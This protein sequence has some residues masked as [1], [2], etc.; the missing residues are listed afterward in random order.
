MSKKVTLLGVI[1]LCLFNV[2]VF[3]QSRTVTLDEENTSIRAILKKIEKQTKYL[4]VYDNAQ[5]DVIRKVSLKVSD[6]P[7]S[8]VLNRLFAGTPV[9]YKVNGDN[10]LLTLV[11]GSVSGTRATRATKVIEGRITDP[12]GEPVIGAAVQEDGTDNGVITDVDGKFSI[13]APSGSRLRIS[14]IGMVSKTIS[15]D[16]QTPVDV[17]LALDS[18]MLDEV[19]AAM[20]HRNV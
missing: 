1:F 18:K 6:V 11:R 20:A 13:T 3:A 17:I 5:I 9:S 8:Q 7:V 10:I 4:F 19:V 16:V 15:S 14:C 12:S 2:S